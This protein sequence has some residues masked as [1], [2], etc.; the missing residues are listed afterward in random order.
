MKSLHRKTSSTLVRLH[1]IDIPQIL[2]IMSSKINCLEYFIDPNDWFKSDPHWREDSNYHTTNHHPFICDIEAF[3]NLSSLN[4]NFWAIIESGLNMLKCAKNIYIKGKDVLPECL[5]FGSCVVDSKEWFYSLKTCGR[6]LNDMITKP[7]IPVAPIINE[8]EDCIII[9]A[10][11]YK[12]TSYSNV[13]MFVQHTEAMMEEIDRMD[14]EIKME[15]AEDWS[16]MDID[17]SDKKNE[18]TVAEYIDDIY[19]Y[20]KKAEVHYKFELM[21]ETL[22]LTM[23]LIARFLA[24]QTVIRKKLQLVG[25][26]TLFLAYKYEEVSISVVEDLI[27]ISNKAYARKEVLEMEKLRVNALQ[28]NMTVPTTYV[29]MWRFLKA[30]QSDRKVEL[31]SFFLIELCLVEYE[32]LGFPPLMLATAAVFTAQCTLA[33]GKLTGVHQKYNMSKYGNAARCEPATFLL[34]A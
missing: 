4:T 32:M 8:I 3:D 24:V 22:Y 17:S 23:N 26:T 16:V 20:C 9:D 30:S 25:I 31:V 19:A 5:V 11:D 21:E 33:V 13:P 2:V 1:Q 27:S 12:A 15:E 6:P 14:E 10:E 34:E 29:F 28:F 7:P 18:L